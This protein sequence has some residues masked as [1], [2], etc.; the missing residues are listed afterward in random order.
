M[1]KITK[2][3]FCELLANNASV[4]VGSAS[5]KSDEWLTYALDRVPPEKVC[6]PLEF[7]SVYRMTASDIEFSNGSHLSLAQ[8]GKREYLMYKNHDG[9]VFVIRKLTV[10]D[11]FDEKYNEYYMAYALPEVDEKENAI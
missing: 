10:W 6:N 2:K 3:L 1:T 7:R 5:R 4:L 11:E 8:A 9:V